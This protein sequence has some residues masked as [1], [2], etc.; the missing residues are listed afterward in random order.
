MPFA[1]PRVVMVGSLKLF[2]RH[3][4]RLCKGANARRLQHGLYSGASR[5]LFVLFPP[6]RFTS[7]CQQVV[8]TQQQFLRMTA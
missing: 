1:A 8:S 3:R 4:S 2:G 7:L 5:E 6:A